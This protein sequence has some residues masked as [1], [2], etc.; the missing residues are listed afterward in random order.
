LAL[1]NFVQLDPLQ[2]SDQ[3]TQYYLEVQL[4]LVDLVG[5][6]GLVDLIHL[7]EN[8]A[9]NLN[10]VNRYTLIYYKAIIYYTDRKEK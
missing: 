2:Q 3:L 8:T 10:I 1:D 7:F 4:L 5:L 6:A 9:E